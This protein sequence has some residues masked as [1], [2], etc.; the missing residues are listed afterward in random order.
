MG[1]WSNSPDF[2]PQHMFDDD[3]TTAWASDYN[4]FEWIQIDFQ[5]VLYVSEVLTMLCKQA[6]HVSR[7]K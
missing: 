5:T 7:A 6:R 1:T 4:G 2:L 3:M